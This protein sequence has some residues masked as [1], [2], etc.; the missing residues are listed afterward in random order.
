MLTGLSLP[1][2]RTVKVECSIPSQP[3]PVLGGG[4]NNAAQRIFADLPL[5]GAERG[6][7]GDALV[8]NAFVPG[9][10]RCVNICQKGTI[11]CLYQKGQ[12]GNEMLSP[13]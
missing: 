5:E 9:P 6:A 10:A 1:A 8:F 4:T 13:F 11:A 12:P 7:E 2:Q 3:E